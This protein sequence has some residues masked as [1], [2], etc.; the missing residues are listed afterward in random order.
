MNAAPKISVVIPAFNRAQCIADAIRSVLAQTFADFELIV[1]DDGSTDGTAGVLE[2]FGERVR[3]IRQE[4]RGVSAARNAGIR[5]ARAEWI[6][7]LDSDDLWHPDKLRRQW[8]CLQKFGGKMCFTRSALDN[9]RPHS[10]IEELTCEER[11]PGVVFVARARDAACRARCHPHI[12]S[13]LVEKALLERAGGFNETLPAAEDTLL[14]FNLSFF[15]GFYYLTDPLVTIRL[16]AANSLTRDVNLAAAKRR[17]L[18]YLRV[19]TEMF[20]RLQEIEPGKNAVVR[21]RIAFYAG[22]R[23]ELACATGD[24][25][26][27]RAFAREGFWQGGGFRVSA[28]CATIL[29]APGMAAGW[30]RRKWRLSAEPAAAGPAREKRPLFFHRRLRW[31]LT[32]RAWLVLILGAAGLALACAHTIQPFLAQTRRVETKTLVVEGWVHQYVIDAAVREFRA[33]HYEQVYTTG[34]P[35][36][37]TDG[38]SND[39]NTSASVGAESLVKAGVPAALVRMAP[40]HEKGRDRTYSSALALREFFQTN[41]AAVHSFNV[42]TEDAHA[43]RTGLLFQE[44]FGTNAA[45][46]IIS[47]PDPDYDP[48][49]WWH[50]S[51]GVREILAESVAWCY[52]EFVFHPDRK[53]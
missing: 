44:A 6:A 29:L 42:L 26:E 50:Y 31:G 32:W 49:R 22:C 36:V 43:R 4:N 25:P 19:Q 53:K 52:A 20:W 23:A 16:N 10:D 9:G 11:G 2:P 46:G 40:S 33:G 34:G 8:D 28:R 51:E 7:F 13:L 38:E 18:G 21:E 37:G 41:G 48:A 14:I 24:F 47:V 5:A 27:A 17:Y 12:Q 35:V 15:A 30:C 45:V 3:V 1:V 39:F